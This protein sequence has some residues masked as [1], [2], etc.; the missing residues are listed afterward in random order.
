MGNGQIL[1][2]VHRHGDFL[3]LR[4]IHDPTHGLRHSI[5]EAA[6][7]LIQ[8]D[9]ACFQPGGFHKGLKEKVQFIRLAADSPDKVGALR[10]GHRLFQQGVRRHFQ[11]AYRRFHLMGNI[12]YKGLQLLPFLVHPAAVLLHD[13]VKPCQPVSNSGKLGFAVLWPLGRFI[14]GDHV[15]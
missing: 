12:R 9:H 11:I 15:V 4:C 14:P 10:L 8:L 6:R 13:L 1:R 2:A 7:F 3:F 5:K